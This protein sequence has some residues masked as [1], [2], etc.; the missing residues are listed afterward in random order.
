MTISI[1]GTVMAN[2]RVNVSSA[3]LAYSLLE[4]VNDDT[5]DIFI[6]ESITFLTLIHVDGDNYF[7]N[8]E[9][10]QLKSFVQNILKLTGVPGFSP[11][12][13]ISP[14]GVRNS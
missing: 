14:P 12:P 13:T 5:N 6:D 7:W 11:P 10:S 2:R 4:F 9:L 3:D 1:T 8:G